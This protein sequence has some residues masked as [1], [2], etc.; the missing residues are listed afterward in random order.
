MA[1]TSTEDSNAE[2]VRYGYQALNRR[3]PELIL[4]LMAPSAQF[5]FRTP[6]GGEEILRGVDRLREFYAALFELFDLAQLDCRELDGCGD[7]VHVRGTVALR[8]RETRQATRASFRHT[9]HLRNG[10]LISATFEDPVNPL[11]LMRAA[12]EQELR[13]A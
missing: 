7:L 6:D 3:E 10:Y 4:G 2:L 11:E 5:R 8:L 1:T 9:Y 13:R 12:S